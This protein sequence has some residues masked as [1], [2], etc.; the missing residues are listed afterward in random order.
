MSVGSWVRF[1]ANWLV[2]AMLSALYIPAIFLNPSSFLTPDLAPISPSDPP[3]LWASTPP[4][5]RALGPQLGGWALCYALFAASFLLF[6]NTPRMHQLA[7]RTNFAIMIF[8][9]PAVWYAAIMPN[10]DFAMPDFK[11]FTQLSAGEV[12]LGLVYAY[13]G[14]W[15]PLDPDGAQP[16]E[17]VKLN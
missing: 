8:L 14:F 4:T 7:A 1:V 11:I 2:P 12:S 9:W 10:P 5:A 16:L 15:V 17:R 3:S 13:T 6:E